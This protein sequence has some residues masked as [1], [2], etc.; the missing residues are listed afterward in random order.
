[1]KQREKQTLEE[2]I[3]KWEEV[4][5]K[6]PDY[7]D[8]YLQ[9]ALLNYRLDRIYATRFY[10]KKVFTLDPNFE[11]ARELEKKLRY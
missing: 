11:P 9:L 2:Q 1:M 5:T 3:A 4:V 8:G 10:L 6:R 7:R